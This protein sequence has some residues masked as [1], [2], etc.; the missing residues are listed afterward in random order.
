MPWRAALGLAMLPAKS[1]EAKVSVASFQMLLVCAL[2]FAWSGVLASGYQALTERPAG[3]ELLNNGPSLAALAFIP[4]LI[5]A[6]PVI[7]IRNTIRAGVVEGRSFMFA[8]LASI[9][10]G[11]WSLLSGTV[12]VMGL[13]AVGILGA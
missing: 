9:I 4:F 8:T 6:A 7:I 3:F 5:F 13:E 12:V 11:F 1:G 10:A 2:G